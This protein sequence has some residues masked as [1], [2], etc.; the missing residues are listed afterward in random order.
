MNIQASHVRLSPPVRSKLVKISHSQI[1]QHRK[2]FRAEI[3]LRAAS[4][5]SNAAIARAIGCTEKTVR[6]W[7]N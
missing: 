1:A 6:K 4:G 3:I 5:K 7:R 2:V